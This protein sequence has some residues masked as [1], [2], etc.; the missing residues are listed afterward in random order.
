MS[1]EQRDDDAAAEHEDRG[2]DEDGTSVVHAS[3]LKSL[4]VAPPQG[5]GGLGAGVAS[6]PARVSRE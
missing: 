2:G 5:R 3:E 6:F 1:L 4:V